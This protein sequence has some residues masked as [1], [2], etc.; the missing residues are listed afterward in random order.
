MRSCGED[1]A[2]RSFCKLKIRLQEAEASKTLSPLVFVSGKLRFRKLS[3]HRLLL[4]G[5]EGF[6]SLASPALGASYPCEVGFGS[7]FWIGFSF[8]VR[9]YSGLRY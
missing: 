7:R 8:L 3:R 1:S 5:G 9:G 6:H 4:L 2:V